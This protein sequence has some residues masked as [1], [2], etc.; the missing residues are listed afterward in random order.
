MALIVWKSYRRRRNYCNYTIRPIFFVRLS[1]NPF[2]QTRS[3]RSSV[4]TH[5]VFGEKF[6]PIYRE[7]TKLF[8]LKMVW[9]KLIWLL[10]RTKILASIFP[11][12]AGAELTFSGPSIVP[13]SLAFLLGSKKFL[14][15]LLSEVFPQ[16]KDERVLKSQSATAWGKMNLFVL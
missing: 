16:E 10:Q 9:T 13:K 3:S 4:G 7:K 15:Q 11:F 12:L 8:R 5:S 2:C 1:P 6:L 14:G